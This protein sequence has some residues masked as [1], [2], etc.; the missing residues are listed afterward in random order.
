MARLEAGGA[1]EAGGAGGAGEENSLRCTREA[2]SKL[3]H[4][5]FVLWLGRVLPPS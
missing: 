1:R 2:P 4:S 5:L 3:S